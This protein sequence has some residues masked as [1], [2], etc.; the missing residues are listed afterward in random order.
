MAFYDPQADHW[1]PIARRVCNNPAAITSS[2]PSTFPVLTDPKTSIMYSPYGYGPA[3]SQLLAVN[4]GDSA[5][6]GLPMPTSSNSHVRKGAWSALKGNPFFFGD[7]GTPAVPALWEF[8]VANS[9][10]RL[11]PFQAEGPPSLNFPCMASA[12]GGQKI[13]IFGGMIAAPAVSNTMNPYIYIFDT[14][15]DKWTTG[16]VI[17][18]PRSNLACA[19]AGDFFVAWGGYDDVIKQTT[20]ADILFF[21]IKTNQWVSQ[22]S[23]VPL[24]RQST[25]TSPPTGTAPGSA[26]TTGSG[27]T[28]IG[29]PL[30]ETDLPA[31]KSNAA[32]IGGGVAGAVVIVAI[33]G[34][35]FFCRRKQEGS[36]P[37]S[38]ETTSRAAAPSTPYDYSDK[39]SPPPSKHLDSP[40]GASFSPYVTPSSDHYVAHGVN[41]IEPTPIVQNRVAKNKPHTVGVAAVGNPQEFTAE[42]EGCYVDTQGYGGQ[43][44]AYP[45][46]PPAFS[47]PQ[48]YG[49]PPQ[50]PQQWQ[51]QQSGINNNPQYYPPPP[52][53]N[54][55]NLQREFSQSPVS[56]SPQDSGTN[57][58]TTSTDPLQQLALVQAKHE[59]T[60]EKIRLEQQAELE[61]MRRQWEHQMSA[62]S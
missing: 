2:I 15:T 44:I 58:D 22:A 38:V 53:L 55:S 31:S 33:V 60:L 30:P 45:P 46:P 57:N 19:T 7:T 23:I 26:S 51:Q 52:A 12:L 28:T 36:K 25:S 62:R 5:C 20:P 37:L 50:Y 49:S 1:E 47:G 13:I 32:A 17:S 34:F 16:S 10:W 35:L 42:S 8:H 54:Y 48:L 11:V 39:P 56:R 43:S 3:S 41:T 40:Y 29:T 21:N 27:S 24:P 61:K 6:V 14:V 18:K 4:S 9:T 59:Q